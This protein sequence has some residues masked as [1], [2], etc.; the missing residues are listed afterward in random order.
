MSHRQNGDPHCFREFSAR[1]P[2]PSLFWSHQSHSGLDSLKTEAIT[3]G[4]GIVLR[5][6]FP[7]LSF[8]SIYQDLNVW[9]FCQN[10]YPLLRT[11]RC[12]L[13]IFWTITMVALPYFQSFPFLPHVDELASPFFFPFWVIRLLLRF[14]LHSSRTLTCDECVVPVSRGFS[15][16]FFSVGQTSISP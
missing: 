11:F 15:F 9:N 12:V 14:S 3:L 4:D 6:S 10:R 8:F 5:S 13:G 1:I 7:S 16:F 2:S